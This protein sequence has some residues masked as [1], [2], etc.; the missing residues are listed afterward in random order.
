MV[1]GDAAYAYNL[2]VCAA[3]VGAT[4][5][6]VAVELVY[7]LAIVLVMLVLWAYSRRSLEQK[8]R[9]KADVFRQL[10]GQVVTVWITARVSIGRLRQT[11]KIHTRIGEIVEREGHP[12]VTLTDTDEV[13]VGRVLLGQEQFVADHGIALDDIVRVVTDDGEDYGWGIGANRRSDSA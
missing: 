5:W 6:E 13:D 2:D 8:R 4:F 3:T 9:Q 10:Q 7:A 1:V 11:A 12:R